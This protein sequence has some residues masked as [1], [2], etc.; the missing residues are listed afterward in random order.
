MTKKNTELSGI[1]LYGRLLSYVLPYIPLFVVSI[2]G[3]AVY[4]GSQVAATEWLKRVIDYVN[5][6][7]GD[8]RLILPLAL[9]AIALVRGI[10]F[11][12][13]NYLLSSISNRLVHNIR[14]ELFNK[15]TVLPSS[16]YDQHSSGH[17]ISRI[18]FNVMQ[19]TGAAT[20]ALK[21]FIRE[22]LLVIGLITY[23][24]FLNWKLAMFLFIAAPFIAIIVG[25]TAR[26]LRKISG[27][28][29]TAMGDVTHV[30]S[31]TINGHEEVKSFGGEEYEISRFNEAS[32]NNR[33]QNLKLEATNS[34]ASPLVQLFVSAALALITWLALDASIVTNMTPG[35]FIA[36]FSAAGMLAKPVRQLSEIN[37][38]IQK[39]LAAAEDIFGQLDETPEK[40][41]GTYTAD[42]INGE[43]SFSNL[44]FSY[45]GAE[46]ANT[47]EDINLTINKGETVAFVG[48][49]G[50]G[51][52][53]LMS[54]LPRFYDGYEGEIM[55]DGVSVSE[56]EIT[57]LRSH[58]SLVSQNVTLFNDTIANNINYGSS[59]NDLTQIK[60]AARKANADTF[61]ELM[62]DGYETQAGD[63][64]VLLSGGQRQRIAIA[65]AI[66]KDASI[67]IL[68]EATSALDSESE[69]YIQEALVA[70]SKN[71][72]TLVIAH[73]L[74]TIESADKIVVLDHGK[75]VE[76]GDHASLI[77]KD[78][79]YAEL[80]RNQF[81]DDL[82][83]TTKTDEVTDLTIPEDAEIDQV[84]F[85]EDSWYKKRLW[86]WV[87]WPF[88]R[89]IRSL[90]TRRRNKFLLNSEL[91]WKPNIPVIVVGNI[92]VGGSGKTPFVI[93][94]SKVLEEQGYKPGIVSR[95][96]GSKSNQFP[97][98]IN[99][100]S[101]IEDSGDE[102]LIIYRNTNR[103]VCISP[104][105][106]QAVKKLLED[107]DT[108]IV[109]SDDGLQHYK[110]G[111]DMEIVVFD[112]I[113]GIGNSLCLPAGPLRE[114][115]ER[116]KAADFIVSSTKRL[117]I[118]E[119]DEDCLMTYKPLE[120]V[121]LSDNR[122]FPAKD[123]PLSRNVHAVAGIGNPSKFYNTLTVLGL[124]LVEHSFPDH[125]QFKDEDLNFEDNHPIL[126]TEKD[127]V[128]C[129]DMKNKNLWY[130]S[131]EAEIE[132]V[133]FKTELLTKLKELENK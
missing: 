73:R 117:N 44:N 49:S 25:V 72:T 118:E 112:G 124:N 18:T 130:L 125:Y 42:Y 1:R 70:L 82:Q 104:N 36:F 109:I 26:R 21:I 86:L 81:K 50:A 45:P 88:S 40:N 85:I 33:K 92:T 48:K 39:G 19:V 97:L 84:S 107:T 55:I 101:R 96:Y 116:S 11:F 108:D 51:K 89:L 37:S 90:V 22:G 3:F 56:Y 61:I 67:L 121:R 106:T 64:G 30:A 76:V 111:R 119:I 79:H 5:D 43:I 102:P 57:N 75:I 24:M 126:M 59:N 46:G 4:S 95:G 91:S 7:I 23:L 129:M 71:K 68:D 60:E 114:P 53:T 16:Y 38:Q 127:A 54:L 78:S 99:E 98:V 29:Q 9:I 41:E 14:T 28:I 122:R 12:V 80:H 2:I 110:L 6:P 58:I 74:S 47:L 100:D 66:L 34:I 8:M 63:D 77:E 52:T 13:G 128:R 15:L 35:T 62:A 115:I 69:N 131:I 65:R 105:R 94:L 31:E 113:R 103:P 87:L 10:G 93:W 132:D 27:R 17:L 120:W 20:N 123:W 32:D 133:K 83:V